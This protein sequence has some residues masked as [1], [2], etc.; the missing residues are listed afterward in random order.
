MKRVVS[1]LCTAIMIFALLASCTGKT[2]DVIASEAKLVTLDD[3]NWSIPITIEATGETVTYTMEQALKHDRAKTYISAY[4]AVGD[5][6]V[7]GNAPQVATFIL[8]G[9]LFK[10][11]KIFPKF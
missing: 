10:D 3:I 1:I 2:P 11:D 9:V 6:A 8:E 5:N 7:G 4:Q